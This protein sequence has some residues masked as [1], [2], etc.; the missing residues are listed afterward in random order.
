MQAFSIGRLNTCDIVISDSSVSKMHAKIDHQNGQITITDLGSTNGTFVNG[1]KVFGTQTLN[2]YDI[3]K[4]G[5][6]LVPWMNYVD[7]SG[8]SSSPS[9]MPS[10]DQ[11]SYIEVPSVGDFMIYFL[12]LAIPLVNLIMAIIWANK[13]E[14]SNI[15]TKNFAKAWLW[16]I[17]IIT[18]VYGLIFLIFA[19][20][21]LASM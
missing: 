18:I 9:N 4:A 5:N 21:I 2:Q 8:R 12:L 15:I 6:A 10:N 16:W 7:F 17:L 20:A 13:D 1:S 14:P 19:G 3:V 11:S